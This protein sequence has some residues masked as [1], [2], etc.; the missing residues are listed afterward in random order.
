MS[1]NASVFSLSKSFNDGMSPFFQSTSLLSFLCAFL[2]D[3][4]AR[5]ERPRRLCLLTL[6]DLAENTRGRHFFLLFKKKKKEVV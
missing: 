6:D 3:C 4:A 1:R 2:K 5:V